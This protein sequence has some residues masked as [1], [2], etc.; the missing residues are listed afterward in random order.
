MTEITPPRRR[1][2][3]SNDR[4]GPDV[5]GDRCR[6]ADVGG[7]LT[8][9]ALRDRL[10]PKV[11]SGG[12]AGYAKRPPGGVEHMNEIPRFASRTLERL[13]SVICGDQSPDLP[14]SPYRRLVDLKDFFEQDLQLT[15]EPSGDMT[16]ALTAKQYLQHYNG[17][18][19]LVRIIEAAVRPA[20]Y[21]GPNCDLSAAV[22]RLN[23]I[24][25]PEGFRLAAT[26][27][28]YRLVPTADI[29]MPE[30]VATEDH[31][32]R[33]ESGLLISGERL[34][35]PE[36]EKRVWGVAGYRVFLSHKAEFKAEAMS[37]KKSLEMFGVSCFV[38]HQDIQP[39]REWVLE[40][41]N[42]LQTM[43]AFLALTTPGFRESLWTNQ[44]V[45]FAVARAVPLVCVKHGAD[46]AG[47]VGK[48][49]A[50]NWDQT[51][52]AVNIIRLLMQHERMRDAYI[53]VVE[54]CDGFDTGNTLANALPVIQSLSES[55]TQKLLKAFESNGQ[56]HSSF[57]FNG[58][59]PQEYG[60]GLAFHL[61]RITGRPYEYNKAGDKLVLSIDPAD[62]PF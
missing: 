3:S 48:Y 19:D 25:A 7:A 16:R 2:N 20:D 46:P 47:F 51:N 50:L 5:D 12:R 14:V 53:R 39:T 28:A 41:E 42:A 29:P 61:T 33:R 34:V 18:P 62:L 22:E 8:L 45:G 9:A 44:E 15:W 36:A 32:W 60:K 10:L 43:D 57:G 58:K 13:A 11:I 1:R 27:R 37:L 26:A 38:A 40:I 52:N 6:A 4:T 30:P 35:L 54:A 31:D 55:Q 56:V 23:A 59:K 17:T 49:Q 24:L 21:I